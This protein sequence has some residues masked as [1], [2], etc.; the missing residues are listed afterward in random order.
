MNPVRKSSATA[1]AY[2]GARPTAA[3]TAPKAMA[4]PVTTRAAGRPRR[5]VVTNAA[6]SEPDANAVV[7]RPKEEA[8]EW[9]TDFASRGSVSWKFIP[10]SPTAPTSAIGTVRSPRRAV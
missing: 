2:D 3:S 8:S 1:A 7:S 4:D 9:N 10:N 5:A 6:A